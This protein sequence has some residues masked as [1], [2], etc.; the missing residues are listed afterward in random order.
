VATLATSFGRALWGLGAAGVGAAA[1]GFWVERT[2]FGLREETLPILPPG[3]ASIRILHLSDLHL[4]PWHRSTVSWVQ[5]LARTQPDLIV[6]TGDFYGHPDAL[7]TISD[8]LHVFAGIP[9]VVVHGSNDF[10]APR[11]VNPLKYLWQESSGSMGPNRLDFEGLHRLYTETLG[12]HDIDNGAVEIT[13]GN[14]VIECVGVGDAHVGRDDLTAVTGLV[15]HMREHSSTTPQSPPITLGVTHAPYRKVLNTLVTQGA[16]LVFA[17]HTH[18][19]QV[20]IP[21]IGALTTNC[22]LPTRFAR[23]LNRWHHGNRS[24]WLNV[25]AGLGTN[26]Y[27]PIRFACPPEAVQVTLVASDIGYA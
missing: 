21:G 3:A 6:G 27:A 5:S 16:D 25:S 17:G 11:P 1:W 12:W 24:G 15:E 8:A 2:R 7:P 10:V 22:D 23:G 14:Q 4:A 20:R 18:G 13:I 9:G 26:I 19:G